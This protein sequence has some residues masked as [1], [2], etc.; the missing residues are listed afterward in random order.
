MGEGIASRLAEFAEDSAFNGRVSMQ[1]VHF[2]WEGLKER[3]PAPPQDHDLNFVEWESTNVAGVSRLR[4][5]DTPFSE[6]VL[7]DISHPVDKPSEADCVAFLE[8]MARNPAK[9]PLEYYVGE[10][11]L[12]DFDSYLHAGE[13]LC[14]LQPLKGINKPYW[15]LGVRGSGTALH[16]EDARWRS[17]NF[18][19]GPGFKAWLAIHKDDN[20]KLEDFMR[21]HWKLG[22][23]SQRL[24]HPGLFIAPSI[25][26][27][28]DIRFEV[29]CLG[30]NEI[31][32][33]DTEQYHQV[34][35]VTPCLAVAINHLKPGEPTFPD[36]LKVC[37]KCGI[38]PLAHESFVKVPPPPDDDVITDD[39][40][41]NSEED[42]DERDASPQVGRKRRRTAKTRHNMAPKR[43]RIEA[44]TRAQDL[45]G[46]PQS[47]AVWE[48]QVVG[49]RARSSDPL[50]NIPQISIK[51]PPSEKVFKCAVAVR[52][53]SAV[54]RLADFIDAHRA[55]HVFRP[56]AVASEDKDEVRRCLMGI[57]QVRKDVQFGEL[58]KRLRKADL[59]H[60]IEFKGQGRI[61]PDSVLSRQTR[62]ELGLSLRTYQRY[63][64]DGKYWSAIRG[65]PGGPLD[66]L[67]CLIPFSQEKPLEVQAK[68]YLEL[69]P[70]ELL[71]LHELLSDDYMASICVP[72]R[73]FEKSLQLGSQ[74]IEF[75]WESTGICLQTCDEIEM[76]RQLQPL[77]FTDTNI[78]DQSRFLEAPKP[79]AWPTDRPWPA[80]PTMIQ[81]DEK[82]CDYCDADKCL[83]LSTIVEVVPRIKRYGAVRGLQAVARNA[84]AVAYEKGNFIGVVAGD[85]YPLGTYE[86]EHWTFDFERP[87]LEHHPAVCQ[88]RMTEVGN[89]F[90]L[91][92]T[93][94]EPSA[95]LVQRRRA[96]RWVMAVEAQRSI[97]DN[98]QITVSSLW[99]RADQLVVHGPQAP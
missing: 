33:T 43:S 70:K 87:D 67:L 5:S 22:A 3:M 58:H 11:L 47:R 98:D 53:R 46:R 28:N 35:N 77:S 97:I 38:L 60:L 6:W 15:H 80:D 29:H 82:Q 62:Q 57:M 94:E 79:T 14:Q 4:V 25:L 66:G 8:D 2:D 91:L 73:E 59:H 83:C 81:A 21:R 75:I 36:K 90:R 88:L 17:Y 50:C 68:D 45:A 12:P 31:F 96:G 48:L 76:L 23:C 51:S 49:K 44:S 84:C 1:E 85:L 7:P 32:V 20:A 93:A 39:D 86:D 99:S 55:L 19:I 54:C 16:C 41:A 26:K 9:G 42:A 56:P 27:E 78:W 34:A 74:P 64:L 24:R 61:R 37:E 63:K 95:M 92:G 13:Q 69:D 72:A 89:C 52:G 71:S 10:P 65:P 18:V 40:S 30:A